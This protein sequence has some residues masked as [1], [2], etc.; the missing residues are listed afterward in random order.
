MPQYPT[1]STAG[2]KYASVVSRAACHSGTAWAAS[3]SRNAIFPAELKDGALTSPCSRRSV[4]RRSAS[5]SSRVIR[6]PCLGASI[7]RLVQ[8]KVIAYRIARSRMLGVFL[9]CDPP[10]PSATNDR[11][12]LGALGF[13][14]TQGTASP[15]TSTLKSIWSTPFS[16][17]VVLLRGR[18]WLIERICCRTHRFGLIA[19][20]TRSSTFLC[21]P[22]ALPVSRRPWVDHTDRS[23]K[24][25]SK[26][27]A[28]KTPRQGR[29]A[30]SHHPAWAGLPHQR[31]SPASTVALTTV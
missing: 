30:A 6:S 27:L 31:D 10:C 18:L 26:S 25:L 20:D 2:A 13:Q 8:P 5:A 23:G 17:D 15:A 9:C 14:I 11:D 7:A 28:L 16:K 24:H 4:F 21:A 3:V 29:P 1:E 12:S 19:F 22:I